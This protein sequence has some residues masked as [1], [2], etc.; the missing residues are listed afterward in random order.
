MTRMSTRNNWTREQHIIAFNVY[1]QIPFGQIDEDTP[2]VQRL[3]KLVG[4][5]VGAASRKLANFARLD[6]ALKQRGVKGLTHGAKGEEE[7]WN[8]FVKDPERLALESERLVAA[9]L[10]KS[11]EATSK[12]ETD[13]LPEIG[14]EREAI[15][16]LRVKQNFFRR[17]VLSAYSFRCCVTGLTNRQL[18][19]ASHIVPWASD[20]AN[21]LN[22]RNGLSLNALHD[23]VF[24]RHLMWIDDK[25]FVHLSPKLRESDATSKQTVDWLMSFEGRQLLLPKDF[26]PDPV[27][28]AKHASR[29]IH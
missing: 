7:V 29:C 5:S 17:R 11:V 14:I 20:P 18:L 19:V 8:E 1:C 15:V 12:I 13:D 3:A 2:E 24:D 9:R 16:R 22:P 26:C 23:K 4:R 6:P 28:I 27:L 10:G 21:R 25:F